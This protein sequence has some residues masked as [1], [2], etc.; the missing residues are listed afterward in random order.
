MKSTQDLGGV[1]AG[2]SLLA[3]DIIEFHAARILLLIYLCGTNSRMDG[4]TKLAKMDFFVR[5]PQ[6]FDQVCE[7]LEHQEKSATHSIESSM[8]RWNYG[9]WDHRYYEILAYLRSRGLLE[10]EQAKQNSYRFPLTALGKRIAKELKEKQEY[11]Q[12][13][14]QM[15]QVKK[16]LGSMAGSKIKK[17]I[18]QVFEQEVAQKSFGEVIQYDD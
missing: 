13:S 7:F 11:K 3:D 16:V 17:L 14:Q 18:Y 2:V 12:L 15:I 1:P 5:Y 9:P 4:L 6:F 10:I 8:I